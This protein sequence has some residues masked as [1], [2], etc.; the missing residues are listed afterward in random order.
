[1]ANNFRCS[2]SLTLRRFF[3]V[4]TEQE[5]NAHL[6]V[7]RRAGCGSPAL[8]SGRAVCLKIVNENRLFR[9]A[10]IALLDYIR[11]KPEKTWC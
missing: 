3:A 4:L 6:F 1:V 7:F 5:K 8:A 10:P 2:R 11:I 9:R